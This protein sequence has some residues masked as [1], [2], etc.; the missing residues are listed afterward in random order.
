M[1]TDQ[2]ARHEFRRKIRSP[3]PAG[4]K[5]S[6]K[7]GFGEVLSHL[8]K[9]TALTWA[10]LRD[11]RVNRRRKALLF[12]GLAYLAMPIDLVP[13]LIPVAGQ[14]DD[15]AAVLLALRTV[16]RSLPEGVAAA[17]LNQA[18]LAMEDIDRDLRALGHA[19]WWVARKAGGLVLRGV[20]ALGDTL[21][22][23]LAGR[24][25]RRGRA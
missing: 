11:E 24:L 10:L 13:G 25:L 14:V 23:R 1:S 19:A 16:L 15:L 7:A 8:P 20:G 12:A 6:A 22:E 17:H 5:P 2:G 9:Y 3:R 4:E 18:G 21:V